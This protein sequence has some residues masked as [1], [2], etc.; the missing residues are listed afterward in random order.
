MKNIFEKSI[1]DEV[2]AR[3]NNLSNTTQPAWG[4]M[5]VAQ[6]LAHLSVSYEFVYTDKFESTKAKGFKKF[7][8]KAFV[9]KMVCGDK[10]YP[11][12]GRTAP[13]FIIADDKDF[14]AEKA[15]LIDFMN[16]VQQ[17]GAEKF[18]GR[19]SH[20]FGVLTAKEWNNSFYKHADHHLTQF[21]V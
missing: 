11:K 8:M 16:K 14:E 9:K 5:N 4:K 21:G 17:E 6:M 7:I 10:P 2:I 3:V 13:D 19:E 12:N 1:N 18:E 15:R 20:S